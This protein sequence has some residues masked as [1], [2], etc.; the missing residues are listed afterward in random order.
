MQAGL[1]RTTLGGLKKRLKV[2]CRTE[3]VDRTFS[4]HFPY[5]AK[6][7]WMGNILGSL[8]NHIIL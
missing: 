2:A 6:T 7:I 1:C 8:Q 4:S 3:L 5:V